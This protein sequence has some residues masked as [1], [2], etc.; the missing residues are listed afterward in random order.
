MMEELKMK[1]QNRKEIFLKALANGEEANIKPLTREEVLL[2]KQAERESAGGGASHWDDIEG[3]PFGETVTYSDTLTWD[4]N[5][6]GLVSVDAFYR[7]SSAT[8]TLEELKKGVSFVVGGR[9]IEMPTEYIVEQNN[10]IH[11]ELAV[12]ALEDN[13]VSNGCT[14]P[15]AGIYFMKAD[16]YDTTESLTIN[17][18]NGFETTEIQTID[19]KYLPNTGGA[20]VVNVI[21]EDDS[22]YTADKTFED[23][24]NAIEKG[25]NAQIAL[26]ASNGVQYYQLSMKTE[27]QIFF[28]SMQYSDI[29]GMMVWMM[30]IINSDNTITS[31]FKTIT[32]PS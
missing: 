20:F 10:A 8:P 28:S 12:V 17:G 2:K 6:E 29:G 18:Y 13:A 30:F 15:K 11:L 14:F 16:G 7:V 5:T 32:I 3:K 19:P 31:E 21:T 1:T 22:T 23:I 9:T 24:V 4:G 27:T 25:V 26:T